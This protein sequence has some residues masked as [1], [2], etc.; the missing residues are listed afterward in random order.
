MRALA[1][2]KWLVPWFEILCANLGVLGVS[3]VKVFE[4]ITHRRDAE[5]AETTQRKTELGHYPECV[6][7]PALR[8]ALRR[9]HSPNRPK[10]RGQRRILRMALRPSIVMATR[11]IDHGS[12]KGSGGAATALRQTQH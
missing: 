2:Q 10:G 11:N 12:H 4:R 3:A 6:T 1:S 9:K 5:N 8:I 7:N